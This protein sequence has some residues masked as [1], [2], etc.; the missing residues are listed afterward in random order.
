MTRRLMMLALALTVAAAAGMSGQSRQMPTF[1]PDTSW[2]KLPNNWVLGQTPSVAVDRHDHLW[3]L[4]RP[5]TVADDKK[6]LAAPAV[7]EFDADG[8]FLNAW[9]GPGQGFD[10]PDSEHGIFVDYRDN[11]WIGGSSPTSTSPTRRSDDML[12]KFTNKGKFLLQIGGYDKSR[13]NADQKA[14][15]KP[16]DAFVYQK[17]NEVFV[18]DGYGNRRVIVFDADT[19]AFKRQWGAFGNVP[20][21]AVPAPPAQPGAPPAP[22]ETT[23]P[24]PQQFGGPVHNVKVS[25][26]GLVY[27]ADRSNR[28]VQV[29]SIDG[30]FLNQIFVNRAGPSAGSAAGIAFSP[31]QAQQFMYVADYGNSRVL[32]LNR[33]SGEVLYQFGTRSATPGNFQGVHFIT[34]DSKGNLYTAEVL[35]GNRAQRFTYTGLSSTPPPNALPVPA[36][37]ATGAAPAEIPSAMV[38]PYRM[39]DRWPHF[40]GIVSG[41]AIGIIPDGKGGTWL[42]HRS[43]PPIIHFDADGS[44]VKRF[45]EGMFVQAHGFCQDRD[46][47]FWAGD[48]GPFTD[49]PGTAGRGFQMFKFSPDGKVLLTLGKAGVSKAGQDTFVGPTACA[50]APNGDIMIAD[51][52][53]PRPTTAQQD[54]DRVMR[55]TKDGKFVSEFGKLGSKPGEFMGPHALAFDSQGR[56]FVADRSNNRV[57][58]FDRN[59]NFLDEWRHFGRPSGVAILKDDT[60]IVA[61]SESNRSIGGPPQAPEGGGNAIRNPGWKNGIRVGSAK[62]GSLKYFVPGTRPEGMAADEQGNIFG[63]LTG[64]CDASPSGGCLQKFVK[65]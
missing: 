53:W 59:M 25:N 57:Q 24:G 55:F 15:N 21:D 46:G 56:L 44:I 60:L 22:L 3:I 7:L 6:A 50:I 34:V 30:K 62:D 26:D 51:G 9:G 45:G 36:P 65:R 40:G 17:T 41:A 64:G 12:L 47:N 54:G 32:V 29:F 13:G 42:H 23:G 20:Q 61:D 52:H 63:G 33:R 28:R 11:V 2:P 18:A 48:S 5:R 16:A 1:Q 35:P 8:K 58:V 4:H 49:T 31:D 43:E 27:V 19:G 14:V 38:N 37:A 10:W 39:L